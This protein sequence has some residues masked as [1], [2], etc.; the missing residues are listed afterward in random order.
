M[1]RVWSV[2]A[3]AKNAS[4]S[5]YGAMVALDESPLQEGL[6]YVGTD[7]GLIRVSANAGES[8]TRIESFSAVPDMSL[9]E[10]LIASSHDA[11]VAYAVI[12]N[13]KRGDHK[14]Y[15]LKSSNQGA[16][17]GLINKG[18]PERGSAHAIVEDPVDPK[19]LY[20][21]TEFGLFFSQDGGRSWHEFSDLPTIA[22]RDLEFQKR[23]DDLIIGTFGLGI[24]ILDDVSPLRSSAEDLSKAATLFA[25]RDSWI[26]LPDNRRGWGGKGDYGVDRYVA[27]NPPYGAV[28]SYYLP[29]EILSLKKQRQKA[30]KELAEKGG[31]NPYPE[32]DA[33]RQEDREEEPVIMLTVTDSAGNV[34][35]RVSGP[36]AKGFHR[37]AWDLR[38]PAPDPISIAEEPE[39]S[40][41]ES[42]PAGP[43]AVPG[44]Y[45]VRL[46]QRVLGVWQDLSGPQGFNLKPMFTGGLVADDQQARLRF[47]LEAAE[48]F[49]A[50]SGADRAAGE[51]AS[52]LDHLLAALQETPAAVEAPAQQARALKTRLQDLQV[53]LN[54]DS[55]VSSRYEPVPLS[56]TGRIGYI[57]GGYW[58]S[59]SRVPQGYRDSL[60]IANTDYTTAVQQL[61]QIAADVTALGE[62]AEAL[63]APWTPGRLPALRQ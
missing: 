31:N 21:G 18:L 3:I 54:G 29:E 58:D 12:D 60:A 63:G 26:Y 15:V 16:S 2:D 10:D 61:Q 1:G 51:M 55:T 36:T 4:T 56:L 46:S 6:L 30:E 37:V 39:F 22:V 38:Y 13:H 43:L 8:W 52:Q 19:L 20:L 28:F 33:L 34:I 7:D 49:R 45:Q 62:E 48:L 42:P 27:E 40:P 44:E 25:P 11:Q 23:E 53:L 59:Q 32:W 9:V 41:W 35:R 50:V 47:E 57:S 5:I 14:P 24:Y 17:W